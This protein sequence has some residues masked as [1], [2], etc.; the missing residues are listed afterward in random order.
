M[1]SIF[2]YTTNNKNVNSVLVIS[3]DVGFLNKLKKVSGDKYNIS[4]F[5][6]ENFNLLNTEINTFDLIVFDNSKN[7]LTK[8][9]D[10]FKQTKSYTFN[11]IRGLIKAQVLFDHSWCSVW[12][13][14]ND[15]RINKD[16]T[17]DMNAEAIRI[18]FEYMDLYKEDCN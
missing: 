14:T 6:S 7:S 13:A 1:N 18:I 8:F 10:V 12:Q 15:V 4:F 17:I 3:E 5:N 2:L 9:V 16:L 11:I